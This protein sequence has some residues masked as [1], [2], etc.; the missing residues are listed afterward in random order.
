MNTRE[1]LKTVYKNNIDTLRTLDKKYPKKSDDFTWFKEY[2]N[3]TLNF[4]KDSGCTSDIFVSYNSEKDKVI[5]LNN[6]MCLEDFEKYCKI[7]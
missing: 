3:F 5:Y 7:L 6:F 1:E 4:I 2:D